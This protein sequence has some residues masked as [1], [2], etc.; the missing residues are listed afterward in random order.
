[1]IV[2]YAHRPRL[3]HDALLDRLFSRSD[4][5]NPA[6]DIK[7]T[8]TDIT[9]V[10]DAPGMRQEDIHVDISGE[11]L[12]VKGRRETEATTNAAGYV[13]VERTWGGFQR[14]FSLH[15]PIK[16]DQAKATYKDG[17]LSIHVPKA[18]EATP[19]RVE[20]SID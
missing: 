6:V 5:W 13:Q 11:T 7:E 18:D 15:V 1:M 14:A 2:N 4:A 10:I 8:E 3:D 19:K 17:V 20:I 12:T 16:S 9:F